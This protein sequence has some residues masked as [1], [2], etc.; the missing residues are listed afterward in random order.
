[1]PSKSLQIEAFK[2]WEPKVH[3]WEC[4]DPDKLKDGRLT[5]GVK[6]VINTADFP[7]QM[8]SDIWKGFT[9]GNDARV[10]SKLRQAGCVMAG[11]T[12]SA[13]F[14]VH[15]P[16]MTR[17]PHNLL[18]TP[19]TSSSGSAAAVA[20]G[21]VD[22]ALGT[23]TAGSIIRPASYC[24]VYAMKPSFGLI[25][26]TGILKTADTLDTVGFFASNPLV[27]RLML[28]TCRVDGP[29]YPQIAVLKKK[30]QFKKVWVLRPPCQSQWPVYALQ[31]LDHWLLRLN[32]FMPVEDLDWP[33]DLNESYGLHRIIYHKSL[34]YY[35]KQEAETDQISD[36][37]RK[38]GDEG[39]NISLRLYQDSL[40]AQDY[41]AR[42]VD[43][44]LQKAQI[45]VTLSSGG[46]APEN[47]RD[48]P[49][50]TCLIWTMCGVPVIHVPLFTAPD[51]MPFGI[52][53][54]ARR[55]HDYKLFDFLNVLIKAGLAPTE[56][57]P[58]L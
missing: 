43:T 11:K 18:R 30:R 51:G 41:L 12:V 31:A 8:G 58:L 17:N 35:F 34:A 55:F 1:M 45:L 42:V 38:Q 32:E 39:R 2:Q 25:P 14:A 23:Q 56:P 7:T 29:D 22:A 27:L 20:C 36:R 10:V 53:I 52:S 40:N 21:M 19:G 48:A 6:D 44:L 37:F 9:P 5:I 33:T 4:Y 28:D 50:D 26:R 57:N 24:G 13:E 47:E 3:A 15:H 46:G 16:G 49:R 54:I